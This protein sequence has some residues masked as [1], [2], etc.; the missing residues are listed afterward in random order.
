MNKLISIINQITHN[1]SMVWLLGTLIGV[2]CIGIFAGIKV[3]ALILGIWTLG[4]VIIYYFT[5]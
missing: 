2:S 4:S 3:G 1:K 5:M